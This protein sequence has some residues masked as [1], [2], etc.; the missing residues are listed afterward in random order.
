MS[1][2]AEALFCQRW[3]LTFVL[4]S[5][6]PVKYTRKSVVVDDDG[7]KCTSAAHL[8]RANGA[9]HIKLCRQMS[10][11]WNDDDTITVVLSYFFP[12]SRLCIILSPWWQCIS[13]RERLQ[14]KRT[15]ML[16]KRRI[17]NTTS[18]CHYAT[19]TVMA[20]WL[21]GDMLYHFHLPKW[22]MMIK[23]R[24][25]CTVGSDEWKCWQV[26]VGTEVVDLL[27]KDEVCIAVQRSTILATVVS[28]RWSKKKGN[29]LK[30]TRIIGDHQVWIREKGKIK[31]RKERERYWKVMHGNEQQQLQ[32]RSMWC[33]WRWWC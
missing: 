28:K 31:T 1:R 19:P 30:R 10:V 7:K 24:M 13:G 25:T 6:N 20:F 33:W 3:C 32:R 18:V 26:K 17:E 22:T 5:S 9:V 23:V 11:R 4:L 8:H 12:N 29:S 27:F 14:T 21:L 15:P 16:L 2:A